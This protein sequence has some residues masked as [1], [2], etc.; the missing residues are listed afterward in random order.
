MSDALFAPES[1]DA[2]IL[3]AGPAES[4]GLSADAI[5]F[6]G[7]NEDAWPASGTTHPLLPLNVQREAGMPHATPKLDWEIA[8]AITR[9]LL[10][11]AP[12]VHFSYARQCDGIDARPSRLIEKLAGRPTG[13]AG[14]TFSASPSRADDSLLR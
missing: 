11:S 1:Q 2:P 14:G 10:A 9:R 7:A 4:A 8:A 12:E 5:W 3:I 13:F 6:M